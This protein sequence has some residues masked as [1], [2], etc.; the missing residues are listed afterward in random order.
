[1][2]FTTRDPNAYFIPYELRS[3]G[4]HLNV[5][6]WTVAG[7]FKGIMMGVRLTEEQSVQYQ[8][9]L[10]HYCLRS[11][12]MGIISATTTSIFEL[13][14]S[15]GSR[16]KALF[17]F[18]N[19]MKRVDKRVLHFLA[20]AIPAL[21]ETLSLYVHTLRT[22]HR[23]KGKVMGKKYL[24][25]QSDNSRAASKAFVI[26]Q[27]KHS[28]LGLPRPKRPALSAIPIKTGVTQRLINLVLIPLWALKQVWAAVNR[29]NNGL[30]T[31]ITIVA[32]QSLPTV[33]ARSYLPFAAV[34]GWAMWNYF[35]VRRRAKRATREGVFLQQYKSPSFAPCRLS[36]PLPYDQST[37]NPLLQARKVMTEC[38]C[39]ALGPQMAVD[40]LDDILDD[41]RNSHAPSTLGALIGKQRSSVRKL[42]PELKKA[43]V[44]ACAISILTY[45]SMTPLPLL[46]GDASRPT[47]LRRHAALEAL[48]E[49]CNRV[50]GHPCRG[51]NDVDSVDGFI[52]DVLPALEYQD[53]L[54]ALKVL[55]LGLVI[56]GSVS[57]KDKLIFAR[58]LRAVGLTRLSRI[59]LNAIEAEFQRGRLSPS[60]MREAF[61]GLE[62]GA[63]EE[64]A[65]KARRQRRRDR[66]RLRRRWAKDNV[67][68]TRE[69][70]KV[71]LGRG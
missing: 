34:P 21:V 33:V 2:D 3:L 62:G 39:F 69:Y 29:F 31:I 30:K 8:R 40:C 9:A 12:F 58:A 41:A 26:E 7:R 28:L 70:V 44:R 71:L 13:A 56:N 18:S 49:Q 59:N 20:L 51:V 66:R 5:T 24:K 55:A 46:N 54:T 37:F 38:M 11:A 42:P 67:V 1:M 27:L 50:L 25:M 14:L 15:K 19:A 10:M 43:L 68:R 45:S 64:D 4:K 35:K 65:V 32:T 22:V 52:Y 17:S 63:D 47:H 23:I 53:Q 48:L 61:K 57:P 60:V 6:Q 36:P 16:K